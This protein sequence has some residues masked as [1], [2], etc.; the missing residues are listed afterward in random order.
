M[1]D[2]KNT[3]QQKGRVPELLSHLLQFALNHPVNI[4]IS[5]F[6]PI[7]MRAKYLSWKTGYSICEMHDLIYMWR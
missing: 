3:E 1:E 5:S 6:L 4:F 2:S 7:G